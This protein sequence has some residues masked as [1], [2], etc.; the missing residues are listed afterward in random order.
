MEF[1]ID[2]AMHE[3]KR[4][5]NFYSYTPPS[6]ELFC[7][8]CNFPVG[9]DDHFYWIPIIHGNGNQHERKSTRLYLCE[10]CW[11]QRK[12]IREELGYWKNPGPKGGKK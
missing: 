2:E 10:E 5:D 6:Q 11:E 1:S 8:W 3:Q 4:F 12:L 7:G 9:E